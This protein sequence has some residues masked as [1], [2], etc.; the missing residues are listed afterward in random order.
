MN[1]DYE[2]YIENYL[3]KKCHIDIVA[4]TLSYTMIVTFCH[5]HD[6]LTL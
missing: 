1:R 3:G 5:T 6:F 2:I 4:M